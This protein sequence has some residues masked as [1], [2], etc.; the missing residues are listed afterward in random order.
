MHRDKGTAQAIR[1]LR[2]DPVEAVDASLR[3]HDGHHMPQSR[4]PRRLG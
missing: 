1:G 4:F 3:W 2:V